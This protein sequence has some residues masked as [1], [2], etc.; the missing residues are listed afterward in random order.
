MV[1]DD[2]PDQNDDPSDGKLSQLVHAM[3]ME[4]FFDVSTLTFP[5]VGSP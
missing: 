5:A 1:S 3:T 4:E 2:G